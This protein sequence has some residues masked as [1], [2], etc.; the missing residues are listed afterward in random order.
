MGQAG[1]P[2]TPGHRGQAV[3]TG[4]GAPY[5]QGEPHYLWGGTPIPGWCQG[6]GA[7]P[8]RDAASGHEA[9]GRVAASRAAY[10]FSPW[11]CFRRACRASREAKVAQE[12]RWVWGSRGWGH[13]FEHPPYGSAHPTWCCGSLRAAS[14]SP[15]PCPHPIPSPVLAVP[16]PPLSP[17]RRVKRVLGATPVS[18]V[19]RGR[20]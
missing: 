7:A 20:S 6:A 3:S 18:P 1:H 2:G 16:K 19:P 5:A 17:F 15:Q 14:L 12:I 8:S 4:M 11:P 13:P 10:G 9:P